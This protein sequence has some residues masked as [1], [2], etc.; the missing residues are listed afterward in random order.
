MFSFL[1]KLKVINKI[2]TVESSSTI[3]DV[4][5]LMEKEK[6]GAVLVLTKGK[7]A[8]IF[9]ERD[10]LHNWRNLSSLALK[11]EKIESIMTK[12]V[13]T[14]ASDKLSKAAVIMLAKKF[15]H[16]PVLEDDKI[17]NFLLNNISKK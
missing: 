15:R 7:L 10:L 4:L 13:K 6:I 16:L 8:G 3:W 1:D 5:E 17:V 2:H 11:S 9:T 14:L 12:N